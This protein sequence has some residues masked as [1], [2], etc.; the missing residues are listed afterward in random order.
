[1]AQSP[2]GPAYSLTGSLFLKSGVTF[3]LPEGATLIGSESLND[4]PVL[5]TRIAGIEMTWPAALINVRD[6]HDVK[7]TGKGAIDGASPYAGIKLS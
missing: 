5:P 2:C 4:Y 7:I 3:D 6:Q 1:M